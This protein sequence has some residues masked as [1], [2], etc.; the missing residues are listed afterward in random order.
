MTLN[1]QE[2]VFQTTFTKGNLILRLLVVLELNVFLKSLRKIIG[3][4]IRD[5]DEIW[6]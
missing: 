1:L 6:F 5:F 2:I 3:H 4:K